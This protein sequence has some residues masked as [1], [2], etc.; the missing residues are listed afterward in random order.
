M[1]HCAA[2]ETW[3]CGLRVSTKPDAGT[4]QPAQLT[5][6]ASPCMPSVALVPSLSPSSNRPESAFAKNRRC[7]NARAAASSATRSLGSA[8]GGPSS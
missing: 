5:R 2:S 4:W 6:P 1:V 7:P 3:R 8:G